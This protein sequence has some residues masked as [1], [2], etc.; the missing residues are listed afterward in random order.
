MALLCHRSH[1]FVSFR[2][3]GKLRGLRLGM[4]STDKTFPLNL[5]RVG[6]LIIR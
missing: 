2:D 5:V 6:H 3:Y 4:G 1:K